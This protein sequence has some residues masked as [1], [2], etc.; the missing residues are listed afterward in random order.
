MA[1]FVSKLAA[2]GPYGINPY[3]PGKPVEE[4][5][6]EYGIQNSIKL[7]SNENPLGPSPL[8]LR[9]LRKAA[10][11]IDS[12]PD[13]GGYYLKQKLSDYNKVSPDQ[14]LL[15]NGSNEVLEIIARAFLIPGTSAIMSEYCFTVYPIVT[16][17]AGAEIITVAAQQWGHDLDAMAAA[18]QDNTRVLFIANPNN[19][20][21][22]WVDQ[23][24][25][26]DFLEQLPDHLVVVLDE[27][28]IEYNQG[29]GFADGL[30]LLDRFPRLIVL[31]TFSKIY[32]LAGIRVGYG[33]ADPQIIELLNRVREPFNVNSLALVA[34]EAALDDSEHLQR[35]LALNQRG[36][37]QLSRGVEQLGLGMIP[38]KGNFLAVD[39]GRAAMPVYQAMLQRGVI[40]RPVGN[41]QMPNHLR[42]TV[43]RQA[44]NRRCLT[45]L[46]EALDETRG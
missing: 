33:V 43:G 29:T 22:T 37:V 39:I 12:Y 32:G 45:A 10:K 2:P 35:S 34:A 8:A 44:D 4:L 26:I 17:S 18:V 41:Y 28:Y 20:T 19:P 40:V 31:R 7:A 13:S 38:S 11:K 9:A 6:R 15:G 14:L 42:I 46:A 5:E 3:Q 36:M 23:S 27:A 16:Q 1:E 24:A 30:K 25:L 21:G